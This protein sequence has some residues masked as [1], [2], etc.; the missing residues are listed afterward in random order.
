LIKK[1]IKE[2]AFQGTQAGS[3]RLNA[4]LQMQAPSPS[5]PAGQAVIIFAIDMFSSIYLDFYFYHKQPL[6]NKCFT[7]VQK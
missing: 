6:K 5:K 1:R 7:N 2:P 3:S 4:R